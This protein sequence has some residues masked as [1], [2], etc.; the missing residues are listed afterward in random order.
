MR[1]LKR[2]ITCKTVKKKSV[3]IGRRKKKEKSIHIN[4]MM[5][6]IQAHAQLTSSIEYKECHFDISVR[7]RENRLLLAFRH[8]VVKWNSTHFNFMQ[9]RN[10]T[11]DKHRE[12]SRWSARVSAYCCGCCWSW[13]WLYYCCPICPLASTWGGRTTVISET[14]NRKIREDLA[15]RTLTKY[16]RYFIAQCYY[17]QWYCII[18]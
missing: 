2:R 5:L 16:K 8:P 14:K 4:C 12:M 3:E 7:T 1:Y 6:Y 18:W 15:R 17:S 10:C 13:S 9:I 11:Y